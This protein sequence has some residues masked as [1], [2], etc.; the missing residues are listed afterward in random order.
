[1]LGYGLSPVTLVLGSV[2]TLEASAVLLT[3]VFT[4][5]GASVVVVVIT[6]ACVVGSGI[7]GGVV[8]TTTGISGNC[9]VVVTGGASG[10]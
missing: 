2:A 5:V 7:G 10:N 9:V 8:A 1:L 6:G 3:D 4:I